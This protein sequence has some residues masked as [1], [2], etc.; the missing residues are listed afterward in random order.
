MVLNKYRQ[1]NI[2]IPRVYSNYYNP[3]I[4]IYLIITILNI[5]ITTSNFCPLHFAEWK[6]HFE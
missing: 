3:F 1:V 2:V 4:I 5:V 6:K